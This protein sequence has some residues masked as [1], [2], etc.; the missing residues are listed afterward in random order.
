MEAM[1]HHAS[2]LEMASKFEVD[3]EDLEPGDMIAVRAKD[4]SQRMVLSLPVN[5]ASMNLDVAGEPL[6]VTKARGTRFFQGP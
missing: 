1:P 5:R 4:A 6:P 3:V 2:S